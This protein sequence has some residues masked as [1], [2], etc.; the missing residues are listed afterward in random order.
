MPVLEFLQ[1]APGAG[2]AAL[3]DLIEGKHRY[4]S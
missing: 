4:K 1:A 3:E 2:E